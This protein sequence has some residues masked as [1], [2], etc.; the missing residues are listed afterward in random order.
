MKVKSRT[1]K[2]ISIIGLV[3][4]MILNF[5]LHQF[6]YNLFQGLIGLTFASFFIYY[7]ISSFQGAKPK[8]DN[9]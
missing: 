7:L 3:A 1:H 6:D 5:V 4:F 2:Q 8:K 9:K